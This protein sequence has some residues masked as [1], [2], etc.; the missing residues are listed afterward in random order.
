MHAGNWESGEE[1]F[2]WHETKPSALST[3]QY[4][5][6]HGKCLVVLLSKKMFFANRVVFVV[7]FF[8]KVRFLIVTFNY[9]VFHFHTFLKP[10]FFGFS[11]LPKLTTIQTHGC[12]SI[13]I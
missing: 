13:E 7:H 5:L 6:K 9:F 8:N 3:S 10:L 11:Y 2:E 12:V 1:A 4:I